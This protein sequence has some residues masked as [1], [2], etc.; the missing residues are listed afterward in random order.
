MAS[1]V[2]KEVVPASDMSEAHPATMEE[3]ATP[4]KDMV[5]AGIQQNPIKGEKQKKKQVFSSRNEDHDNKDG[6][7]HSH[8]CSQLGPGHLLPETNPPT[9]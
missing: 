1:A 2:A 7:L 3:L 6:A 4:A 8:L 5:G 9:R